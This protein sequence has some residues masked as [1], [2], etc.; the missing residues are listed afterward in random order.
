MKIALGRRPPCYAAVAKAFGAV[1]YDAF[2]TWGDTIYVPS[3]R[4]VPLEIIE[5]ERVHMAQQL[6]VE[7]PEWWRR[8]IADPSFRLHQELSAYAQH[9]HAL[10]V[11][12]GARDRAARRR[13][14]HGLARVVASP[15]YGG[16]VTRAEA[17]QLLAEHVQR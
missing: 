11:L 17:E 4:T 7:P 16:M 13:I 10:V 9:Y 8:Y 1:V 15:M 5:H 6:I 14:L 2:F 3:G 12:Q